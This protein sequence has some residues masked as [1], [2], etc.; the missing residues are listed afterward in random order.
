MRHR[1]LPKFTAS[2][3]D[4]GAGCAMPEARSVLGY[5]SMR[6][7]IDP[8]NVFF[9]HILNIVFIDFLLFFYSYHRTEQHPRAL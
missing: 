1:R 5:L 3:V 2:A 9:L 7:A 4:G 8:R 6:C